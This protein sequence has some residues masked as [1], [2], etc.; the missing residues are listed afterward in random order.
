MVFF[1]CNQTV[2]AKMCNKHGPITVLSLSKSFNI[3]QTKLNI[4]G[5]CIERIY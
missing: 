1:N 5:I 2:Q 4:F 3:L